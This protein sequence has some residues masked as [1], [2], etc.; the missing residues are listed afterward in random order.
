[1]R[2]AIAAM[3]ASRGLA[4]NANTS[5]DFVERMQKEKT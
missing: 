3:V 2:D 1:V 4:N 5:N